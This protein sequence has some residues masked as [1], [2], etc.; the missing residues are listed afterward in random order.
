MVCCDILLVCEI[1]MPC[2]YYSAPPPPPP[3]VRSKD[4]CNTAHV[5][6]GIVYALVYE[7]LYM[8]IVHVTYLIHYSHYIATTVTLVL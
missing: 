6:S 5:Y 3:P 4:Y 7:L 1:I 2:L 8:Y